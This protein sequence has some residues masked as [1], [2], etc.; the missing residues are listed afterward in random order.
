[1]QQHRLCL[2]VGT[3]REHV[4][5]IGEQVGA[6]IWICPYGHSNTNGSS[7]VSIYFQPLSSRLGITDASI[8]LLSKS[9]QF[10]IYCDFAAKI[11]KRNETTKK[12][13]IK[14]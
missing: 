8:L 4:E 12:N 5:K 9:L 14:V 11:G 7:F 2:T 13:H 6:A 1:M 3:L 10:T